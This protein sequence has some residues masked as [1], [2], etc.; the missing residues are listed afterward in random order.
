L[1][2]IE[3]ESIPS[4][5]AGFFYDCNLLDTSGRIGK[6]QKARVTKRQRKR[7]CEKHPLSRARKFHI[8]ALQLLFTIDDNFNMTRRRWIADTST[9]TTA[10]LLGAQ[11]EH[12][13]RVLRGEPGTT[14]EIVAD[15]HLYRATALSVSV[16]EVCFTLEEEI[17]AAAALPITLLV[18]IFKFDRMEWAIEKATELGVAA[19]VPIIA[20]RTEKHLALS[21]PK[22]VER[23]RRLAHEAA[24]QSRRTD[25]PT[26]EDPIRLSQRLKQPSTSSASAHRILLS[27]VECDVTLRQRIE[28][29]LA[30]SSASSFEFAI[31]P[32]GGWTAE[33]LALFTTHHWQPAS[34]GPR[35]L[36]VET[37]AIATLSI[38]S[39]FL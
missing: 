35:I 4:S 39:A 14:A 17:S 2:L 5:I 10:S 6:Q 34:L 13:A 18:A 11:A 8:F 36:R 32:E 38:A 26:I 16:D 20:H 22:R 28:A 23:W 29:A 24:K 21:A 7:G 33:E 15:G 1:T 30:S 25:L 3:H 9:N 19:I 12:F 27:E 31:G 37:A